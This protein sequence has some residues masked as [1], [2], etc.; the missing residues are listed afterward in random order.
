MKILK[1]LLFFLFSIG[2]FAQI[3]EDCCYIEPSVPL[4]E[5]VKTKLKNID[6]PEQF[7]WDD[8]EGKNYLTIIRN[9]HIP[10]YCGGCWAFATTSSLSDRIKIMRNASYPDYILSPQ[11]LISCDKNS[12]GCHGGHSG[13][14]LDYIYNNYIT[15]E[16]CSPYRARGWENGQI[17]SNTTMCKDCPG[18]G[19][20]CFVPDQYLIFQVSEWGKVTGEANMKQ[21]IYQRGPIS[22]SIAVPEDLKNYSGGI[23]ED[24]TGKNITTHVVSVVGYGLQNGNKYWLVRNSWG[25]YWGENGLFRVVRGKNNIAIESNCYWGVPKDTWTNNVKHNTTLEEKYDPN[26]EVNNT[27]GGDTPE[28]TFLQEKLFKYC[29]ISP[30]KL[31]KGPRLL[32]PYSHNI[33]S[34][35]HIPDTWDW[36]DVNGTNYLS[37]TKNQHIPIYCGS[38]WAHST[39][40]ALAD[41]FNIQNGPSFIPVSLA[42]QVILNC[43]PGGG[44]CHGGNPI[45]VYE[46]IYKNGIPD[47]TC[48]QYVAE[49]PENAHCSGKQI[50]EQC[51]QPAPS[52]KDEDGKVRCNVVSRYKNYYIK[53]YGRISGAKQMKAEIFN[54]GPID[55]VIEVTQKFHDSYK[56]G[57]YEEIKHQVEINHA[58]SIVGYG[59]EKGI[60]YWVVRNSWG[61]H[62]GEKGFFR[63]RMYKNNL[64]IETDCNF[65]IPSYEKQ[66]NTFIE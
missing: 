32:S 63:I 1:S 37:I 6:L 65:A 15:E 18:N 64:G 56:E 48:Q 28:L 52:T 27:S 53:E 50:C 51:S 2:V 22:C 30:P 31:S 20:N 61:S 13:S 42:T 54:R 34:E 36:R 7:R 25:S 41:R 26:N 8:V 46:H 12:H 47:E 10:I 39:T 24:H 29:K 4:R 14:A 3:I 38:C 21:E 35:S 43:Q 44:S 17:C 16:N 58:I 60:E 9:Q 62:W 45:D 33:L 49:D 19:G 11:V 57:I 55:C 23:Y 5:R 40:S 59:V 66:E